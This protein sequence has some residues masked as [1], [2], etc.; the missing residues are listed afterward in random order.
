MQAGQDPCSSERFA[1]IS[2]AQ[3]YRVLV[4]EE[5]GSILAFAVLSTAATDVTL[6]NIAVQIDRRRCGLG[7]RLLQAALE[8]ARGRGELRCLL[9]VRR[10]NTGARQLYASAGF[11]VDGVRKNYYPTQGGREDALLMSLEL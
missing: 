8:S 7:N 1:V 3:G 9:E 10:S 11:R 6:Q 5:A 2:E 4:L